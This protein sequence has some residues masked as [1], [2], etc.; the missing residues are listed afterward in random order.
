MA[1]TRTYRIDE[2][3]TVTVTSPAGAAKDCKVVGI[4]GN[5][6]ASTYDAFQA[7]VERLLDGG[8]VRLVVDCPELQYLSS[9]GC[10]VLVGLYKRLEESGGRLALARVPQGIRN[11]LDVLQLSD[12]VRVLPTLEDA[13]EAVR[14]GPEDVAT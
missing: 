1:A 3:C 8:T 11:I 13:L 9:S 7:V 4:A 5:L 6:D 14:A 12:Y 10:G 2:R